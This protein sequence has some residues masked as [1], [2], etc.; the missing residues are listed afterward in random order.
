MSI[1]LLHIKLLQGFQGIDGDMNSQKQDRDAHSGTGLLDILKMAIPLGLANITIVGNAIVDTIM[2][3]N[4]G[5]FELA[6]VS[7]AL[8]VFILV[9]IFGEGLAL[10]FSPLFTEQLGRNDARGKYIV[11]EGNLI[12]AVLFSILATLIQY[13]AA[14]IYLLLGQDRS[15]AEYSVQYNHIIA[16]GIFP[17]LV[18]VIFWELACIYDKAKF[19]TVVSILGFISNVI[20]NKILIFGTSMTPAYGIAGAAASTVLVDVIMVV[21]LGYYLRAELKSISRIRFVGASS[22]SSLIRI[23]KLGFP[24]GLSELAT[25]GFFISS[26]F[27]VGII[28][29]DELAAHAIAFHVIELAVVFVLGFEEAAAVKVGLAVGMRQSPEKVRALLRNLLL[30]TAVFSAVFVILLVVLSD[31]IPTFFLTAI[32]K[33]L[34]IMSLATTL[35]LIGAAF[36]ILDALQCV[37]RGALRGMQDT[38]VPM[39]DVVIGFWLVGVPLSYYLSQILNLGAPGVWYGLSCGLIVVCALLSFRLYRMRTGNVSR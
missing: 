23:F 3:G 26:T 35:I 22:L 6:T 32:D 37:L 4:I 25:A 18:F 19:I 14:D 2:V 24:I 11:L 38:A 39:V 36:I 9:V 7:L 27:L 31:V 34:P 29:V 16:F 1:K 15:I 28:G 12:V 8:Q 21:T 33:H 5:S 30:S 17:I 10:S 20:L 13:N